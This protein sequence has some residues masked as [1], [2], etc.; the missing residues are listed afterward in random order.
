MRSNRNTKILVALLVAM[1]FAV[2]AV[3]GFFLYRFIARGRVGGFHLDKM[4]PILVSINVVIVLFWALALAVPS[5]SE[6]VR[7]IVN[8]AVTGVFSFGVLALFKFMSKGPMLIGPKQETI[9]ALGYDVSAAL[10]L[11]IQEFGPPLLIS[12][13]LLVLYFSMA[14]HEDWAESDSEALPEAR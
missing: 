8:L 6:T 13:A 5:R 2:T 11:A 3:D 12:W 9:P 14:A 1:M 4:T 10:V 7:K